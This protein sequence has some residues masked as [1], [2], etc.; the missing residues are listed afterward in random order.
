MAVEKNLTA[1]INVSKKQCPLVTTRDKKYLSKNVVLI[2]Y[3]QEK[4]IFAITTFADLLV[5]SFKTDQ[6]AYSILWSI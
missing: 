1:T 4:N 2:T 3:T 5:L 6:K